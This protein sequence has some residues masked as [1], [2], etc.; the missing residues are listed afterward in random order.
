MSKLTWTRPLRQLSVNHPDMKV[1]SGHRLLTQRAEGS[2]AQ[3]DSLP[4]G[5]HRL[6]VVEGPEAVGALEELP[7]GPAQ[8]VCLD[9]YGAG[10]LVLELPLTDR[11]GHR[12][13]LLPVRVVGLQV[14]RLELLQLR[15]S[16]GPVALQS[17]A[18]VK[19]L[20]TAAHTTGK[21]DLTIK[22][23]LLRFNYKYKE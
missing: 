1:Q 14:H 4:V 18:V 2:D 19:Y 10:V 7:L 3:V 22:G 8:V 16:L 11:T 9:V 5:L 6:L 13:V 17:P 15:V 23:T 12:H 21:L 20:V